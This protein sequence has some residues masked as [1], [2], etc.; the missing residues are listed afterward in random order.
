MT[1]AF[2]MQASTVMF[3]QSKATSPVLDEVTVQVSPKEADAR[4]DRKVEPEYPTKALDAGIQ[5][6]VIL[7]VL[8]GKNGK[9]KDIKVASGN[10]VLARAAVSAVKHWRYEPWAS[11]GNSVETQT[12][13]SFRFVLAKGPVTCPGQE[14]GV[15]SFLADTST[16][17]STR[18]VATA[19]IPPAATVF[20]VGGN[21]KPPR[22][23]YA[24][25]PEYSES[26][27]RHKQQG[28]GVLK[29]IVTP[30]GKV[31]RVKVERVIGFGLDQRAV[32]AVCQWRFKPALKD[33]Q[34]VPV[35]ITVE[36]T[37]RLY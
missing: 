1:I 22:A 7:N 13:V 2:V 31:A 23:L 20:K 33:G 26:A 37:F 32:N 27:Q 10:S 17:I 8:I 3:P 24:P 19:Q 14:P 11:G 18:D 15:Y 16:D 9:V 28:V 29:V 5:G 21:V 34:P 30:E 36:M 4:L 35:E 25:D 12:T 6:D